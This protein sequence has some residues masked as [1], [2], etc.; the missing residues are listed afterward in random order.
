MAR[1]EDFKTSYFSKIRFSTCFR[2]Y[3]N[4]RYAISLPFA[5]PK[6]ATE[7]K[8]LSRRNIYPKHAVGLGLDVDL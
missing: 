8:T 4:K 3:T 7:E 5:I 6:A 2:D 1:L